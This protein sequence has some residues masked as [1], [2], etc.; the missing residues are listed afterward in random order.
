M[1]V[2]AIDYGTKRIG[3][4]VGEDGQLLF[5]KMLEIDPETQAIVTL[6]EVLDRESIGTIV[7]GLPRRLDGSEKEEAQRVR[8]FA[9]QL[10]K[11]RHI[12]VIFLDERLT[13]TEARQILLE[14]GVAE[15]DMRHLVDQKVAELLLAQH[16]RER[17]T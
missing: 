12:P 13:S 5:S 6:S 15:K 3:L 17:G 7:I 16:F 11:G 9:G 10:S 2:A 14:E 8:Q 1:K 4:A